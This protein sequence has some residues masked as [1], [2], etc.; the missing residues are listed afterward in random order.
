MNMRHRKT[1]EPKTSI[2]P[3]PDPPFLAPRRVGRFF[4]WRITYLQRK[5]FS[6]NRERREAERLTREPPASATS[7]IP[8]RKNNLPVSKRDGPSLGASRG[9]KIRVG[10]EKISGTSTC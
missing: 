10:A 4:E 8:V 7:I 1:T 5:A 6:D 9:R 3:D 2:E